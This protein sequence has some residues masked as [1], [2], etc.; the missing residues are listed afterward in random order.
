MFADVYRVNRC[1]W[2]PAHPQPPRLLPPHRACPSPGPLVTEGLKNR[3]AT[4]LKFSDDTVAGLLQP[5]SRGDIPTLI[6]IKENLR[7][8]KLK[9]DELQLAM[10]TCE[11]TILFLEKFPIEWLPEMLEQLKLVKASEESR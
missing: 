6:A 3:I 7:N 2:H 8:I 10:D 11:V 1:G 5:V 4:L 9:E